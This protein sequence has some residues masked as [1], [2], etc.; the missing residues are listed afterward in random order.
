LACIERYFKIKEMANMMRQLNR[1][2]SFFDGLI[3]TPGLVWMGQNTTHI[4]P[5]PEVVT[6]IE[7]S[8]RRREFQIYAPPLGFDELRALVLEDL[9]LSG[10]EAIITDGAVSGLYHA[11]KTLGPQISQLI[12]TDPG[13]PWPQQFVEAMG[14]PSTLIDIYD[15]ADGYKLKAEKLAKVLTGRSLIYLIDPLNPLGSSYSTDELERICGLAKASQSILIHDCTYRHF[16]AKPALAASLYPDGTITTYSFSKWLGLAGFRVGAI[17]A[18]PSMMERLASAPP[19]SLGAN[20]VAQRAA[21]AGLKISKEWLRKVRTINSANQEL[22]L[23]AIEQS[24]I[25]DP[26]VYPSNGNFMAMG[27]VGTRWTA[28][29]IAEELL[30]QK[31]FI[32]SGSYQSV[33]FGQ[34]FIKISTAVPG[35]WAEQLA[36]ALRKLGRRQA[37]KAST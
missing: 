23:A 24:G 25:G 27:L 28:D 17:I 20:I 1:R 16:A 35:E 13:W 8:I 21:I 33:K 26:L 11:C 2:N 5:R 14:K 32:R 12:T 6:A 4:E 34:R 29:S 3:G 31:L 15:P 22:I 37:A 10:F 36:G 9:G 7:E 18:S 19:N 30:R